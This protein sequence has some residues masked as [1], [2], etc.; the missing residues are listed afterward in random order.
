LH[1]PWLVEASWACVETA[2]IVRGILELMHGVEAFVS[3]IRGRGALGEH[4]GPNDAPCF[5]GGRTNADPSGARWILAGKVMIRFPSFGL[6]LAMLFLSACIPSRAQTLQFLP[7]TDTHLKLNSTFRAY[8]EAKE[9][10]DG[11]ES[12]QFTIGPSIQLYVRPLI[13]LK[14]VRAFDLDDSK[15]RF[16]VLE[17]GYRRITAPDAPAENRMLSAVTFNLSMKA[18]FSLSDRNRADLDW[19][20]GKFTWR[21][22]NKLTADRSFLI[23]SYH[24]I[25]YVAVEPYYESQYS[26]WSTTS[27]YAGGLFPVG[28]HVEFNTYYEHD[29]NTGKHPNKQQSSVG[30]AVYIYFSVENK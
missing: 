20:G 11:G 10:R 29:N 25:P 26:K 2:D 17:T 24:F 30:L 28:K 4:A 8:L 23:R 5:C 22:R 6:K 12:T 15:S 9:D 14:K 21:Y 18:G 3:A 16:L 1:Q 27:L 13:K 7:E 19:K